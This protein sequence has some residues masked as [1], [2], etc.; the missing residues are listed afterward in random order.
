MEQKIVK[1]LESEIPNPP[2]VQAFERIGIGTFD[3]EE[4]TPH[5]GNCPSNSVWA[6]QQ[7]LSLA[8]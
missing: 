4:R 7:A 2:T 6:P 3:S 5:H 1:K 8:T